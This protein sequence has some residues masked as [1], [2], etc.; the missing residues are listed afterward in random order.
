MSGPDAVK[1]GIIDEVVSKRAVQTE[2]EKT[3][4]K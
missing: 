1:F 3:E 2:G 4:K